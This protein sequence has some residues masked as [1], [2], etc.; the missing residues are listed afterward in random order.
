VT[1]VVINAAGRGQRL[2]LGCTKALVE[3]DGRSLIQWQ[4]ALLPRT[5]A[6]VVGLGYQAESVAAQA[7]RERC[8]VD[9]VVN[10]EYEHTGAAATLS[11]GSA[12]A[13]GRVLCLP[14]DL[15]VHPDDLAAMLA[16]P[17]DTIGLVPRASLDPVLACTSGTGAALRVTAVGPELPPG[18][19][20]W[21]GLVNYDP[22]TTKL[23]GN[24]NNVYNYVTP[25]LPMAGRLIRA[26][27]LDFAEE[28]PA[29]VAWLRELGSAAA[30]RAGP[31]SPVS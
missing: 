3:V 6:V 13:P 24:R 28:L 11:R 2:G 25:G 12:H 23:G 31:E 17:E 18:P 5:A 8:D 19:Y 21:S 16:C 7:R 10:E 29:M 20:E 14:V 30:N 9:F 15:I 26:R 1:T 4:L 22:R 27:E